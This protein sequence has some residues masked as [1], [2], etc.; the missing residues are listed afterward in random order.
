[1][2]EPLFHDAAI[3]GAGVKSFSKKNAGGVLVV[4]A[5]KPACCYLACQVTG[6]CSSSMQVFVLS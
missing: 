6:I 3:C 1:M 4:S 5:D 2:V